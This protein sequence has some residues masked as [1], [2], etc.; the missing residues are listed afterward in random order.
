MKKISAIFFAIAALCVSS[1]VFA[2]SG[3]IVAVVDVQSILQS[4][5]KVAAAN[6]TLQNRFKTEQNNLVTSEKKFQD[7]AMK[8]RKD[9]SVMRK[10]DRDNL[11]KKLI[12]ERKALQAK[13]MEFQQRVM[14][15]QNQEMQKIV[16]ELRSIVNTVAN[17]KGYDMV[18]QSNAVVYTDKKFDL[19]EDVSKLFNK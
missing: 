10:K 14:E 4:S 3:P 5:P 6:K 7:D 12:D 19:T 13:Q 18:I 1:C 15:A 2:M 8:F 9:S 16:G 17:S 11:E